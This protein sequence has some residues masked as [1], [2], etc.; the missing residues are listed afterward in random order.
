MDKTAALARIAF[1]SELPRPLLEKLA[2]LSGLQRMDRN[3]ILFRQGEQAQFI[4]ALVEGSVLIC[5]NL[6]DENAVA[7]FAGAGD[8]ILLPPALLGQPY[9]V[10]AKAGSALLAVL[11]PADAFI[12][13]A[14]SELALATA[15]NRVLAGHWYLLLR[16]LV[17]TRPHGAD[18]RVIRYLLDSAGAAQGF[19]C[20]SLP[21]SKRDLAAHL[22]IT[23]E[24]LSRSLKRI[25]RLGV[26]SRGSQIHIA[27][28]GRLWA[29]LQQGEPP[30]S[31]PDG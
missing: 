9:M 18:A 2:A 23:P 5:N 25:S 8:V 20:L 3:T 31:G 16:R 27:D 24:T 29:R 22:G 14:R 17:Q 13:L 11:I 4:Y 30:P 26:A 6:R 21:G 15:L 7:E 1:F 12:R 28:V 19:A 10:T